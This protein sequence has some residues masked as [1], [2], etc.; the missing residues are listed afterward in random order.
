MVEFAL[1]LP[2]LLL[3]LVGLLEFGRLFYAWLIIENSTRFGIRYATA[4][5]YDPANCSTADGTPC[6]G[7]NEDAEVLAARLPSIETETKRVILGFFYNEGLTY[8]KNEYLNITVCSDE[9]EFNRPRMGPVGTG[10]QADY[11][12]CDVAE[13]AGR[14]GEQVFVAADYNFTFIVLPAL[15]VKPNSIHLA[16]YR[17]GVNEAF[18]VVEIVQGA[19]DPNPGGRGNPP[20]FA[21]YSPTPTPT[22]TDTPTITPTHTPTPTRTPT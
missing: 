20:P 16:S 22:P 1:I 5:T 6:S 11:A 13:N 21:N 15:G 4:G 9:N 7:A 12:S 2:I 14:P 8:D 10:R 18:K 17:S 3:V 19:E